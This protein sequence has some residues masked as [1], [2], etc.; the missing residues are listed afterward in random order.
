MV[1]LSIRSF[2]REDGRIER[3]VGVQVLHAGTRMEDGQLVTDGGRVLN[4]VGV[5]NTF[6]SAADQVYSAAKL[7][8]VNGQP[9]QYRHDIGQKALQAAA[10]T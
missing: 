10:T 1:S 8:A 2:Y 3:T 4:L 9:F 6:V 5:S 7:I